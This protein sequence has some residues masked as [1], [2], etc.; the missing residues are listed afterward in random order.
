MSA[1]HGWEDG[2]QQVHTEAGALLDIYV[3]QPGQN[4]FL[5]ASAF[6]GDRLAA[7]LTKAIL[8]TVAQ[9]HGAP[10]KTPALCLCCPRAV[11]RGDRF[12]ISIIMPHRDDASMGVGSGICARCNGDQSTLMPRVAAALKKLWPDARTIDHVFREA[13]HT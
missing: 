8:Q 10:R 6:T 7:R 3:F 12:A 13:G 2:I 11:R 9:I 1:P 4:D 5:V